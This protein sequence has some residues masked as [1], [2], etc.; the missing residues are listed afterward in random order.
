MILDYNV[1]TQSICLDGSLQCDYSEYISYNNVIT[2]SICLCVAI[3]AISDLLQ[4]IWLG[5]KTLPCASFFF[6]RKEFVTY[7]I[8]GTTHP[9]LLVLLFQFLLGPM[10]QCHRSCSKSLQYHQPNWGQLF[11]HECNPDPPDELY[12]HPWYS[13]ISKHSWNIILKDFN[14]ILH[15]NCFVEYCY[16]Y[17]SPSKLKLMVHRY[18][19][20]IRRRV[21]LVK[22]K[23]NLV[24]RSNWTCKYNT[25]T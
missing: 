21:F 22:Q 10:P 2:Q 17:L 24:K 11:P 16:H 12:W 3:A 1:I 14:H 8:M 15:F 4:Y 23:T 5:A 9:I 18:Q 6:L 19:T 25:I 20:N 13:N 7:P